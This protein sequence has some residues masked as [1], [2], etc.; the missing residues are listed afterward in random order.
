MRNYLSYPLTVE[1]INSAIRMPRRERSGVMRNG[2]IDETMLDGP[3]T[4]D[5]TEYHEGPADYV[6]SGVYNA[7]SAFGADKSDAQYYADRARSAAEWSPPQLDYEAGQYLGEGLKD[8]DL[9]NYGDA[10]FNIAIAGTTVI[11]AA[12][13]EKKLLGQYP[14]TKAASILKDTIENGGN[15]VNLMTGVKPTTGYSVGISPN[16]GPKSL[17]RIVNQ[18]TRR[19]IELVAESNR[20]VLSKPDRLLGTWYNKD[21]QNFYLEPA[22]QYQDLRKAVKEGE[23]T[24]QLAGWDFANQKEI[25][26]GNWLKFIS[27][28]EFHGRMDDM[29]QVGL[30]YLGGKTDKEWWSKKALTDVYGEQRNKQISGI[31]ASTAPNTDLRRNTQQT[32]EYMRR[33]IK[34][35]PIIQKNYGVPESAMDFTVGGQLGLESGRTNNLLKA[36]RGDLDQLQRMKVNNQARALEGDPNAVVLDTHWAHSTEDPIRNIYAAIQKNVMPDG[37]RYLSLVNEINIAAARKGMTPRDYSAL[38]WTG[39]RQTKATKGELFG[40]K[41]P[42]SSIRS[43]SLGYSDQFEGIMED[44]AKHLGISVSKLVTLLR[45]GD[46]ELLA[47]VMASPVLYQALQNTSEQQPPP[48]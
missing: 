42:K 29:M 8:L 34:G 4:G 36:E 10:A 46:A 3:Y 27:S 13:V 11:P 28:D 9:G 12:K 30:D 41:Y 16:S 43:E 38:V 35:E 7:L 21:D 33:I 26:I 5:L 48:Q 23:K 40:V 24:G 14:T 31:L 44:K 18:P 19:D 22:Q 2:E 32:S 39:I 25:P 17:V 6:R 37:P 20:D 45:K 47:Y 1:D 15:S